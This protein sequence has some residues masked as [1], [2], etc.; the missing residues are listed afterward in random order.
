MTEEIMQMEAH[1]MAMILVAVDLVVAL[2]EVLVVAPVMVSVVVLVP[3]Q[4]VDAEQHVLVDADTHVPAEHAE[5]SA[6]EINQRLILPVAEKRTAVGGVMQ[7]AQISV[8]T[9]VVVA[10]L[11][12]LADAWDILHVMEAIVLDA[13]ANAEMKQRAVQIPEAKIVLIAVMNV[14]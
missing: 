10:T 7:I 13:A 14:L 1:G 5:K 11:V 8:L 12:A 9:A 3:P 4:S 6:K 2:E